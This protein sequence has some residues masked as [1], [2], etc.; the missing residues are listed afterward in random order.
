[1]LTPNLL[2]RLGLDLSCS[3]CILVYMSARVVFSVRLPCVLV[4]RLRVHAAVSD[5]AVQDVVQAA[6]EAIVPAAP[7]VAPVRHR[8]KR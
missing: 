6:L 7:A 3:R 5:V 2:E 4:H 1:M 8:V